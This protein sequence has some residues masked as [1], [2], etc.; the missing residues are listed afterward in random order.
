MLHW[1]NREVVNYSS[2]LITSHL[3][4]HNPHRKSYMLK[5]TPTLEISHC[6]SPQ[7]TVMTRTSLLTRLGLVSSPKTLCMCGTIHSFPWLII[8]GKSVWYTLTWCTFL[9]TQ[10]ATGSDCGSGTLAPLQE[11]IKSL[12]LQASLTSCSLACCTAEDQ[13]DLTAAACSFET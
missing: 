2:L 1:F 6:S 9:S 5:N 3:I 4:K 11:F 7:T 13:Y 10:I 12:M 8:D